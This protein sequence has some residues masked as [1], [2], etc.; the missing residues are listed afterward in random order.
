M[1]SGEKNKIVVILDKFSFQFF[2][3]LDFEMKL[4][5]QIECVKIYVF[6]DKKESFVENE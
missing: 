6:I 5:D 2:V 4:D 3:Y 1:I